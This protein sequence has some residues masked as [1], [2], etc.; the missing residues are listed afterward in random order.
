MNI[1]TVSFTGGSTVFNKNAINNGTCLGTFSGLVILEDQSVNKGTINYAVFNTRTINSGVI[2]D[3]AIFNNYSTNSSGSNS[4]VDYGIFKNKSINL[5][6]ARIA[7]LYDSTA[8]YAVELSDVNYGFLFNESKNYGK[9]TKALFYDQ[10]ENSISGT[11]NE[12]EFYK[13]SKNRGECLISATFCDNS[14]NE[15]FLDCNTVL[16]TCDSKNTLSG[17]CKKAPTFSEDAKNFG[18][19]QSGALFESG[20]INYGIISGNPIF[21]NWSKNMG[22]VIGSGSFFDNAI[23]IGRCDGGAGFY[24]SGVNNSIYTGINFV[25]MEESI[26]NTSLSGGYFFDNAINNG[27][28]I[29][30]TLFSASIEEQFFRNY[31]TVNNGVLLSGYSCSFVGRKNYFNLFHPTIG[32]STN[33]GVIDSTNSVTF[34][35][36]DNHGSIIDIKESI[37]FLESV[38]SGVI[39]SSGIDFSFTDINMGLISL[40][41]TSINFTGVNSGN[42]EVSSSTNNYGGIITFD[43]VNFGT[44][45]NDINPILFSESINYGTVDGYCIM[46][47]SQN[48]GT[49]AKGGSIGESVNSGVIDGSG[50]FIGSINYGSITDNCEFRAQSINGL[51]PEIDEYGNQQ[52]PITGIVAGYAIFIE[53]SINQG[54]LMNSGTFYGSYNDGIVQ[55]NGYFRNT[56]GPNG[57]LIPSINRGTVYGD[58]YFFAP[59]YNEG[60]VLG[61]CSGLGCE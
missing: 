39:K 35:Y 5:G 53:A 29:G 15:A 46:E 20:S 16:F 8:N 17:I 47:E 42:I 61:K 49:L 40:I 18:V 24:G 10:S 25:F 6:K 38:N 44:I 52:Q 33:K 11:I 26:N 37:S 28:I 4:S 34:N 9:I 54:I 7:A 14:E 45:K 1:G 51:K 32:R 12:G 3:K 58:A 48:Q 41:D 56:D 36:S 57:S 50:L 55:G 59:S 13:K 21:G 19:L 31:Y 23:N 60:I 43:G 22:H 2:S 27:F 30:D